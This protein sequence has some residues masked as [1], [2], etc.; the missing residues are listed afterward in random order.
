VTCREKCDNKTHVGPA[1]H[2]I[3]TVAAP[4]QVMPHDFTSPE[5]SYCHI[6]F[7][8][9]QYSVHGTTSFHIG[10]SVENGASR[11]LGPYASWFWND[12]QLV[13]RN[14]RYGLQPLYYY[15]RP[16]EI[17]IGTSID[18]LL[19]HGA[20]TELDEAALAVYL[21][22]GSFLST[23]T[24][25]RCISA[26]PPDASI[27]W[28]KGTL[29]LRGGFA[30][31]PPVELSETSAIDAYIELFRQAVKRCL[32]KNKRIVLPLS[33]GRDSRHILLELCRCGHPPDMAVTIDLRDYNDGEVGKQLAR[34]CG[35]THTVVPETEVSLPI[36]LRLQRETSFNLS[37]QGIAF[38]ALAD[39][40]RDGDDVMYDGIGG[41]ILSAG[42][43]LTKELLD[44]FE[45]R[46]WNK[47]A[48]MLLETEGGDP[49]AG[50]LQPQQYRKLGLDVAIDRLGREL[51]RHQ[52]AANPVGSFFFWN[53]TRRSIG[54]VPFCILTKERRLIFAPYLDDQLFDFLS[55]I[56]ARLLLDHQFHT[57]AIL[58]AFPDT[59]TIPFAEKKVDLPGRHAEKFRFAWQLSMAL[60][61]RSR[62]I[63]K[64]YVLPRL[65]RAF[66]DP[67]DRQTIGWFGP[68]V[69]YIR[70]L[71][72]LASVE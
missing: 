58:R 11:P 33:G 66:I 46:R 13:V 64:S 57:R 31:H 55:A 45:C 2:T 40:L 47:A 53:R 20:P 15:T 17:C 37:R 18:T 23:D 51:R 36:Y 22:L 61:Q 7:H 24:P 9:R 43:F 1:I 52:N 60:S 39:Y 21:R 71:E 59:R 30:T 65:V 48:N 50:L 54:S 38:F 49:L 27:V 14:D 6:R 70:S 35:I 44:A 42:L 56:P 3:H 68:T 72:S 26:V 25:F 63:S 19:R 4:A 12:E 29:D 8:D 5:P 67:G 16:N 28:S 41:D 34:A 32:V 69:A 10:H 62:Y